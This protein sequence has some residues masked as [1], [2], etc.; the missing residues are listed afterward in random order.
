MRCFIN[1]LCFLGIGFLAFGFDFST[2]FAQSLQSMDRSQLRRSSL[3]DEQR[4]SIRESESIPVG[5]TKEEAFAFNLPYHAISK[6]RKIELS[7]G[8]TLVA[9]IELNDFARLQQLLE[10]GVDPN[11]DVHEGSL[12]IC[13]VVSALHCATY[14]GS[15]EM[16]RILI[17]NG[18]DPHDDSE[19]CSRSLKTAIT[20]NHTDIA[21]MILDSNRFDINNEHDRCNKG[22]FSYL[23][24]AILAKNV[25]I[26][27]RLL[28]K[29]IDVDSLPNNYLVVMDNLLQSYETSMYPRR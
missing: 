19:G 21:E 7:P 17:E 10:D 9:Y 6:R 22:E 23:A 24:L 27:R 14:M 8:E 16:A 26:I 15:I 2:L 18:A 12:G 3:S 1:N 20:Y 29:G 25:R 13:S 4:R 28:D 5:L 11:S